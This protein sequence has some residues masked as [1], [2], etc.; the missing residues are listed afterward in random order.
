MWNDAEEQT[1]P[2]EQAN[3]LRTRVRPGRFNILRHITLEDFLKNSQSN[4]D[5]GQWS[6]TG[7]SI[8]KRVFPYTPVQKKKKKQTGPLN[9]NQ[10]PML[11][12]IFDMK[13]LSLLSLMFP[14]R[15][16]NHCGW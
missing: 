7:T 16:Q 14:P 12:V 8:C 2:Q 15:F 13:H 1:N 10:S 6:P 5:L 3:Y 4:Q 9:S 11:G